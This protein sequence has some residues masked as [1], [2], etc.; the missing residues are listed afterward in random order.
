VPTPTAPPCTIV[1]FGA[2]GDLTKRLLMPA[3]YDLAAAGLLDPGVA[4]IGADH[5]DRDAD[6]WRSEIGDALHQFA[7]QP[8]SEFHA[9]ALDE[10]AWSFVAERMEYVRFDFTQDADFAALATRLDDAGNA[11]FYCAVSPRFFET[12]AAGLA[13]AG[14]LEEKNGRFRR[15]IIEKPFGRD[16]PSAKALNAKLTS[17]AT[18]SQLYRIDHFLGKDAVQGIPALRFASRAFEPLLQRNDVASVQITAAETVGVEER[19]SFYEGIGALRDMVPNHLFSLLTLVAM[20]PPRSFDAE[21]VR[22]AKVALLDAIRPV[23]ASDAVRG[24]YTAGTV[25]G[26]AVRAYRDEDQV[27]HDSRTETYAAIEVRIDND[28]WRD[29]PFYIRTGKCM[30]AHVT[31]IALTLRPPQGP[32]DAQPTDPHLMIFGIDPQ[33]GLVQ[34]FAAKRPGVDM[35]LGPVDASFR[36]DTAFDEP[37]NVG[38]ETLLYHA[39]RGDATLFQRDDMIEREWAALQPVLDAWS[40]PD[41]DPAFYAAGTNGPSDADALLARNGDRWLSVAPLE[42]LGALR[43][44]AD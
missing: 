13:R 33:R 15:L 37:P 25:A 2:A 35:R 32:L 36:Y 14:L 11:L 12:I 20:E 10:K 34:R 30:S 26:K 23:A 19:G 40:R 44:R 43:A 31:T 41:G 7:A 1:V 42:S 17:L 28:R 5:N 18:E 39:M 38:Y 29:V 22:D 6:G 21:D 9:K 3:V 8:G 4:I 27:A 16:L 24:Q